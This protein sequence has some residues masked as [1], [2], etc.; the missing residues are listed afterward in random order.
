[1]IH[2]SVIIVT[3][4]SLSWLDNCLPAL[5]SQLF[6]KNYEIIIVDNGST[7]GTQSFIQEHFPQAK[8]IQSTNLGF[9]TGNNIGAKHA[10]GEYLAFVNPDTIA[11]PAWLTN[12][13]TPLE[14]NPELVTTSKIVLMDDPTK[15]NTCGNILHFTGFGFV[16]HF[17]EESN[18]FT[19]DFEVDGIS[20]AAFAMSK[21]NYEKLGGFD[22]DFFLYMEDVEL[23]WR[24]RARGLQIVCTV[25][26][27]VQHDYRLDLNP[28]K[29]EWLEKGRIK[30]LKKHY[31]RWLWFILS[32]SLF[33]SFLLSLIF[34]LTL[35]LKGI[36]AWFKAFNVMFSKEAIDRNKRINPYILSKGIPFRKISTNQLTIYSGK[37]F[38]LFFKINIMLMQNK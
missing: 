7:D 15:I 2:T 6:K 24:I 28:K 35:N 5:Y 10:K 18:K 22:E 25:S 9:G 12:L 37:I 23:S 3:Y 20:G 30:I 14:A 33:L 17:K 27:I 32:P 4:N 13:V 11:D 16:N 8:L 38:N 31:T 21:E 36:A 29:I 19:T 34:S 1:M 26:S